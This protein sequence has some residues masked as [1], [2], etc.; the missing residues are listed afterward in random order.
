M[1]LGIAF[2]LLLLAA[3][4]QQ[5]APLP[6]LFGQAVALVR[7]TPYQTW[8]A[9]LRDFPSYTLYGDGRLLVAEKN[10]RVWPEAR[11]KRLDDATMK[12]LY[13]KA[14]DAGLARDSTLHANNVSDAM[15]TEFAIYGGRDHEYRLLAYA[16]RSEEGGALG[17]AADYLDELREVSDAAGPGRPYVPR[18]VAAIG[19]AVPL[20][21]RKDDV[22]P[23]PFPP[24]A[25]APTV[26]G[27]RCVLLEGDVVEKAKALADSSRF[28]TFWR[29]G[30]ATYTV[31]FRPL[32]PDE[33]SCSDLKT[34]RP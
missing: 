24:L 11:E 25:D 23:W 10:G 15:A 8:G 13:A 19:T 26:R 1:R 21:G 20:S 33:T 30:E 29:S 18:K 4:G 9:S 6:P 17:E 22:R 14:Y 7:V 16:P 3:C 2:V 28:T 27:E 32:L 31:A 5:P 12:A 34:G